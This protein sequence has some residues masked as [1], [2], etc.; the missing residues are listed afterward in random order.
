VVKAFSKEE[1]AALKK[2]RFIEQTSSTYHRII[3]GPRFT[4]DWA[5][6]ADDLTVQHIARYYPH[7]FV[8]KT[9]INLSSSLGAASLGRMWS[10]GVT[11]LIGRP[12]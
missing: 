1:V 11:T 5:S 9:D 12:G 8:T 3:R 4:R 7:P 10:S 2:R 6:Q